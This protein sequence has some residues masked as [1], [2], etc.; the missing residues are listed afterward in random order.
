MFYAADVAGHGVAAGVLMSMV[1]TAVHMYLTTSRPPGEGLLEAVNRALTPLTGPASYATFAYVLINPDGRV[2][3]SAAGHPPMF[4]LQDNTV[5]R[6][7][8]ENL[9]LAMFADTSYSTQAIEFRPGDLLTIVTDGLT[10]VFDRE[11][12]ELGDSY[13]GSI[14]IRLSSRPLREIAD[15]I[16]K[17]ARSFGKVADDQ[18]L[19]IVRRRK[20]VGSGPNLSNRLRIR[21]ACR[22]SE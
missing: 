5:T 4:H 12:R 16:F 1:K 7:L 8:I 2:T 17:T 9:P 14:L 15:E 20:H 22:M 18:S 6:H 19:L 11:D 3:Y 10:E 21:S 13:I